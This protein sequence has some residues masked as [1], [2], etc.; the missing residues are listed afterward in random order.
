MEGPQHRAVTAERD[1]K[2][3]PVVLAGELNALRRGEALQPRDGPSHGLVPALRDDGDAL[4]RLSP[5]HRRSSRGA[6]LGGGGR[7]AGRG[8]GSAHGFLSVPAAPSLP[9]PPPPL[10]TRMPP[11]PPRRRR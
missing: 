7:L 11:P 8:G 3:G 10:P 4:D 9:P 6:R 5:P 1:C 2:I